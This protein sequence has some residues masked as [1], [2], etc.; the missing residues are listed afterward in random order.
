MKEKMEDI[1]NNPGLVHILEKIFLALNAKSLVNCTLV[2]CSLALSLKNP[3]FWFKACKQQNLIK[4]CFEIWNALLEITDENGPRKEDLSRILKII[5]IGEKECLKSVLE[6][7]SDMFHP[8]LLSIFCHEFQLADIYLKDL[9]NLSEKEDRD[10]Y[11]FGWLK[12]LK[13]VK[14]FHTFAKK[15]ENFKKEVYNF[16]MEFEPK[17]W[18]M[19]E[20]DVELFKEYLLIFVDLVQPNKYGDT[21]LHKAARF[22][23]INIVRVLASHGHDLDVKNEYQQTPLYIAVESGKLEI[24]KFLI[25]KNVNPNFKDI[26]GYTL[27]HVAA[28]YGYVDIMKILISL[29]DNLG[30]QN[31]YQ[32][33]PLALAVIKNEVEIVKLLVSNNIDP[34]IPKEYWKTPYEYAV[35]NGLYTITKILEPYINK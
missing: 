14:A 9:C 23:Y 8:L 29:V 6:F 15:Y 12:S 1:A 3:R 28:K 16:L 10:F 13:S 21:L 30:I 5:C 20:N 18:L 31:V 4:D 35:N 25:S 32:N 2:S 33:T 34:S 17:V 11:I 24:V 26:F 7:C 27:L 22:G 19:Y